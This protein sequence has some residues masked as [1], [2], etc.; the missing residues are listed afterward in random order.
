MHYHTYDEA[1]QMEI[2]NR[3]DGWGG[4]CPDDYDLD[5]LAEM[6][7]VYSHDYGGTWLPVA[8]ELDDFVI[9]ATQCLWDQR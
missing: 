8:P 4:S 6:A 1:V 5:M 7:L 9:L 2:I 3:I